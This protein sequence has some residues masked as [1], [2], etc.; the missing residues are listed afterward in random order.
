[1]EPDLTRKELDYL[2]ASSIGKIS[3]KEITGRDGCMELEMDLEPNEI[4]YVHIYR[5]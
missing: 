5:K 3:I 1:M 4:R 2:R